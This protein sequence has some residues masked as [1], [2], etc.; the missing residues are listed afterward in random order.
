MKFLLQLFI[1]SIVLGTTI[2]C[3]NELPI[4][5]SVTAIPQTIKVGEITTLKCVATDSDGDHLVY[6]LWSEAGEF[7]HGNSDSNVKWKS[8]SQYGQF[9]INV[10]VYD[11]SG[12]AWDSVAV[13]VEPSTEL[14]V[15]LNEY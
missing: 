5:V 9:S 14:I 15:T 12:Y 8:S 11:G 1:T 4:I 3:E 2:A 7:V 6:S 13:Y 10:L